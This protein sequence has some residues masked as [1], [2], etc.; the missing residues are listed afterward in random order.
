VVPALLNGAFLLGAG[1]GHGEDTRE[2]DL[3]L[4]GDA[5][6]L[7]VWLRLVVKAARVW[8]TPGERRNFSRNSGF[9]RD[10][11]E[12]VEENLS[13]MSKDIFRLSLQFMRDNWY[14]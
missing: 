6:S 3:E 13:D 14:G 11:A 4:D 9:V 5:V 2:D 8:E 10:L 12:R 1:L 7:P